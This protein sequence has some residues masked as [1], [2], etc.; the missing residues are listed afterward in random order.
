MSY[1]FLLPFELT[2]QSI[3]DWLKQL[4]FSDVLLTSNEIYNV[5]S[6]LKKEQAVIDTTALR[7]VVM[8]L[9][10]LVMSLSGFLEQAILKSARQRKISQISIRILRHLAFLHLC[11]AKR[12]EQQDQQVLHLSY[13]LQVLG[14]AFK[15]SALSYERPSTVLWDYMGECYALASVNRLLD[16]PVEKSLAEFHTLATVNL[17]LKRLLLFGVANP[18]RF[19]QQDIQEFFVFCTLNSHLVSL[20]NPNLAVE[21]VFCWDY[22]QSDC[23]QAIYPK[24]IRLPE[25]CVL[26]HA[27]D[28]LHSEQKKSL[29]IVGSELFFMRLSNYKSLIKNTNFFLAKTYVIASGFEQLSVFFARH[30]RNNEILRLNTPLPNDLNFTS[31]ELVQDT[32]KASRVERVS[33]ADI[34]GEAEAKKEKVEVKFGA[35][36]LRKTSQTHFYVAETMQVHLVEGDLFVAYDSSLRPVLGMS[37]RTDGR[38]SDRIQQSVVQLFMGQVS[39]LL[40]SHLVVPRSALLLSHE[41]TFELFLNSGQ[42]SVGSVLKFD[43]VE[44]TLERLLEL[45]PKFMRYA[46]SVSE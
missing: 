19:S 1:P 26:F 44:V 29:S 23:L 35:M 33:A 45:S 16:I 4:K 9:T 22:S 25:K 40:Q 34:W 18:Y 27:N 37:R 46:V 17:A 6:T 8:R 15:L 28:L 36:K 13:A 10:P 7:L 20:V 2:N 42:Y 38:Q 43:Q 3:V 5:L 21:P 41:H 30:V 14:V 12:I 32:V 39:V 11:L 24:P 31:L